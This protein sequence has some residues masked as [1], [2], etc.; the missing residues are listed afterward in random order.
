MGNGPSRSTGSQQF[1]ITADFVDKDPKMNAKTIFIIALSALVIFVVCCGAISTILKC[2]KVGRP[3]NAVGPVF[4]PA[5]NKRRATRFDGCGVP[6]ELIS[7][8]KVSTFLR[9]MFCELC[10]TRF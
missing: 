5:A 3:S 6:P 7:F 1:P 10:F 4:T 8:I 2:R 9:H